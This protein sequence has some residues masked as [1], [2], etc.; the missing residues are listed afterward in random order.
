MVHFYKHVGRLVCEIWSGLPYHDN[1]YAYFETSQ[2]TLWQQHLPTS[3]PLNL[4]FVL[5][6]SLLVCLLQLNI[7]PRW[8]LSREAVSGCLFGTSVQGS[9]CTC[10]LMGYSRFLVYFHKISFSLSLLF[11]HIKNTFSLVAETIY[12]ASNAWPWCHKVGRGCWG[13]IICF[14]TVER[15]W[16]HEF[17][18]LSK[19]LNASALSQ[20]Q[21]ENVK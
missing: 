13:L 20:D 15:R 12:N 14:A 2:L 10:I 18:L 4:H 9:R 21:N 3:A 1:P 7:C 6:D 19:H 11:W 17:Y 5:T 8:L 16:F